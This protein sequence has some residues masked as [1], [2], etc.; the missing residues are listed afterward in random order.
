MFLPP[1]LDFSTSSP[2]HARH[3]II[4]SYCV[5][6]CTLFNMAHKVTSNTEWPFNPG[7]FVGFLTAAFGLWVITGAL[8]YTNVDSELTTAFAVPIIPLAF[9]VVV[10]NVVP[11][12]GHMKSP[13]RRA[14]PEAMN[15]VVI[16]YGSSALAFCIVTSGSRRLLEDMFLIISSVFAGMLLEAATGWVTSYL[17]GLESLKEHND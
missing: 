11:E 14:S 9:C 1:L 4:L 13:P 5:S 8:A 10:G 12:Y 7:L 6:S 3:H 15:I 17:R 16:F 2:T